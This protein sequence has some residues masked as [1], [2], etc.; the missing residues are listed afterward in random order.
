MA[1][2]IERKFLVKKDEAWQ[3]VEGEV[4]RQGYLSTVK[5]RT[6]RV[7]TIG[8][9]GYLTIKGVTRGATRLEFEYDIPLADARQMLDELC[10]RPLIEKTRRKIEHQG[11]IWEIDQFFGV[12]E[13]LV[14]AEIELDEED[15]SFA[16]PSWI[17]AEVTDDPRY[18]NANLVDN[19]FSQWPENQ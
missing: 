11:F 4:Y 2:E 16:K 12:N 14:V 6:V 5:E 10:E 1:E 13:G 3:Q 17:G 15:Q 7:R 18:F 19:P 8:S 9:E